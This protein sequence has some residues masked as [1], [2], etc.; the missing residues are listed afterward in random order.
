MPTV[1]ARTNG[2]GFPTQSPSKSNLP[3]SAPTGIPT[4]TLPQG[5]AQLGGDIIGA[6]GADLFGVSVALSNDGSIMAAGASLNDDG[7]INAGHV[8]VFQFDSRSQ[9]WEP[10]GQIIVGEERLS[11]FGSSIALSWNGRVMAA[12]APFYNGV[13][14][15]DSGQV[16][17]Y[18]YEE[19]SQRWTQI[20]DAIDGEAEGD[21]SGSTLAISGDGRTVAIGSIRNKPDG[22]AATGHVRLFRLNEN[23]VNWE[24][25]GS[26]ID[27]YQ[28][29]DY[30]GSSASLS[31][32]GT[33][34]AVG[35]RFSNSNGPGSG[36]VQVFAYN[37]VDWIPLGSPI[38]GAEPGDF[39]GTSVS[40]S[41][42]GRFVAGG[43]A[44]GK[45]PMG[46]AGHVRV[47]SYS[48]SNNIWTQVGDT[49]FGKE[50]DELFGQSV[51]IS[52]DGSSFAAGATGA[53]I[54]TG[55]TRVYA[56]NDS[57]WVQVG[58]DFIGEEIGDDYGSAIALSAENEVLAI[59]ARF[60]DAGGTNSGKVS[61]YRN[62]PA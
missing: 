40:L 24:Q 38:T 62:F 8:R 44:R 14:G 7:G 28:D 26:D 19:T 49:V 22:E 48:I 55:A 2:P 25:I 33:I 35:A 15:P 23:T 13:N 50:E 45:G 3:S 31:F 30:W 46:D 9:D 4:E 41:S 58:E 37:G 12:S 29:D 27:G 6:G 42:T 60:N 5:W 57:N 11:R 10:F 61:V 20:G 18:T 32:D 52:G 36:L 34:V 47:F 43:S 56:L 1:S 21:E 53:S 17:V 39:F 16:R 59:G 51:S 54:G